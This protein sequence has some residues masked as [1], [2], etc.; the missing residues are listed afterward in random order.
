MKDRDNDVEMDFCY[1]LNYSFRLQL[2]PN[3]S[4]GELPSKN[5][6]QYASPATIRYSQGAT[7]NP[8]DNSIEVKY[9]YDII[10]VFYAPEEVADL[11]AFYTEIMKTI[12]QK[13]LLKKR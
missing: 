4:V 3:L 10:P 7:Y 13:L 6:L 11:S 1:T 12:N 5:A 2:N 9:R 8:S